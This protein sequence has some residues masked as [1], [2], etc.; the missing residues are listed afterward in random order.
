LSSL[1]TTI[2]IKSRFAGTKENNNVL[3][4]KVVQFYAPHSV[5]NDLIT[6]M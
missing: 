6:T 5:H 1:T 4:G 3:K 2:I